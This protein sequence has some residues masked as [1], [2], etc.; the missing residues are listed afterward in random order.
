MLR[1]RGFC[2]VKKKSAD[3][4]QASVSN[5][6]LFANLTSDLFQLFVE[7]SPTATVGREINTKDVI[8]ATT[9]FIVVNFYMCCKVP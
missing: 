1:K 4:K 7:D 3:K 6:L 2:L 5:V 9:A 8:A